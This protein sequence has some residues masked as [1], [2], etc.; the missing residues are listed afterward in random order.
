MLSVS[1]LYILLLLLLRALG[2]LC[3]QPLDKHTVS[4]NICVQSDM[5]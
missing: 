5:L 2:R 1:T 4:D 3:C